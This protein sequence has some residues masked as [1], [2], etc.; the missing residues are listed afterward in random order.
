MAFRIKNIMTQIYKYLLLFSIGGSLYYYWEILFRGWS[1]WSMFILGGI[2]FLFCSLQNEQ[3]AWDAPLLMQVLRCDFF[4]VSAE[5]ITGCMLNLWLGWDIWNY[6][7]MP[8]NLL[9]QIC[10]P[11]ALGF[12]VLCLFAIILDDWIRYLVFSEEKPAYRIIR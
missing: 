11:H 1:H 7:R 8:F 10:L 5:F 6:D 12:A 2:C 3:A 4:V 9:G